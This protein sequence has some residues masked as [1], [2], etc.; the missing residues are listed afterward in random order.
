MLGYLGEKRLRNMMDKRRVYKPLTRRSSCQGKS[1]TLG[2]PV[3]RDEM[4]YFYPVGDPE[5]G[6]GKSHLTKVWPTACPQR[7]RLRGGRG[8]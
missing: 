8:Q 3:G 6:S 7:S 4:G 2:I 1:E 5:P